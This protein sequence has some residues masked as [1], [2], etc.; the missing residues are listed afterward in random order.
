MDSARRRKPGASGV[1]GRSGGRSPRR[2]RAAPKPALRRPPRGQQ[3]AGPHPGGGRGSRD[4]G[5]RPRGGSPEGA[6]ARVGAAFC[7][8]GCL[9]SSSRGKEASAGVAFAS[10]REASLPTLLSAR[11]ASFHAVVESLGT[12]S[13]AVRCLLMTGMYTSSKLR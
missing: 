10:C 3:G 11:A 7:V 12:L 4:A 8:R 5:A 6:G 1:R 9:Q 13:R 2:R